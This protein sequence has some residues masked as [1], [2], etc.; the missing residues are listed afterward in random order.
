MKKIIIAILFIITSFSINIYARDIEDINIKQF[1]NMI[2]KEKKAL[3]IYGSI[4]CP[5]CIK[6]LDRIERL[7]K[8]N[9]DI[10]VKYIFIPY[11]GVN[12]KDTEEYL[13]EHKY[14][15]ITLY[16]SSLDISKYYLSL[17]YNTIPAFTLIKNGKV[18]MVGGSST[19]NQEILEGL[20]NEK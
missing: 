12:K 18:I 15:F 3:Y 8:E 10:V 19:S 16:N 11:H 5:Y 1:N 2:K 9:K 14:T 7:S 17:D 4:G 20:N 6:E 13:E